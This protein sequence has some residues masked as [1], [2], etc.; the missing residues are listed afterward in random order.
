MTQVWAGAAAIAY[1]REGADVVINYYPTEEPDAQEVIA[2]IKAAGRKGIGIP[3]DLRDE[4]FCQHLVEKAV[5]ALGGLDIVVNNAGRQQTHASIMDISTEQFD[6]TM[7]KKTVFAWGI[8]QD[9]NP[10]EVKSNFFEI[11]WPPASGQKKQFPEIDKA[12]WLSFSEGKE[13]IMASQVPLLNE[14]ER[15]I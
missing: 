1:A 15:H 12:A 2:L 11:E 6:W 9:F 4:V 10:A 14:I 8:E 5:E 7:N 3:G 13:R